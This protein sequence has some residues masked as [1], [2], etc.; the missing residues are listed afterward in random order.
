MISINDIKIL[1][2]SKITFEK[3]YDYYQK[4]NVRNFKVKREKNK[5]QIN[6]EVIGSN[7]NAYNVEVNIID[8]TKVIGE[9]ECEAAATY[10]GCCKHVIAVL[11]THSIYNSNKNTSSTHHLF[12]QPKMEQPIKTDDLALRMIEEYTNRSVNNA[13]VEYIDRKVKLVPTLELL[14]G[15]LMMN[16]SV[17]HERQYVIKDLTK[18]YNDMKVNNI[19]EYGKKLVFLHN[20]NS[21]DEDS[22]PLVKFLLNR[23][24]EYNYYNSQP[25]GYYRQYN[26]NRSVI[27]TPHSL[28]LIFEM[29]LNKSIKFINNGKEQVITFFDNL[30]GIEMNI[31][32]KTDD[33]FEVSLNNMKMIALEGESNGYLILEDKLYKLDE[34]FSKNVG[35]M[36]KTIIR[37]GSSLN[38]NKQDMH[39]FFSSVLTD[40]KDYLK[41]NADEK[42][43][44]EY[45]PIPMIAKLYVDIPE[46][47][48]ITGALKFVYG[49]IEFNSSE[50]IKKAE[51]YRSLKDEFIAKSLVN[52]Y[53]EYFDRDKSCYIIEN[54]DLIFNLYN[55]G[56]DDIAKVVQIYATDKFKSIVRKPPKVNLG[57]KISNNLLDIAFNAE[58]FPLDELFSIL[59]SYKKNRKFHRLKDG[60]FVNLENSSLSQL[61]QIA[62][63]L[64]LSQKDL[65]KGE[66]TVPKYRALYLDNII[67]NSEFIKSDRDINFKNIVRDM[68][69]VDDTSFI[70]PDNLKD[71]LRNYQKT[72]FHWLKTLSFYGFGG[73]LADDMGLGKT[74]EVIT[75]IQSYVNEEENIKPTLIVCPASLVL[76]WE[77]EI[78]R[79]APGL[80]ALCVI[81]TQSQRSE[82]LKSYQD[83]QIII[84]SYDYLKRDIDEY[85]DKEFM[86]HIIDEAQYIKNNN[87]LNSKSVKQIRSVCRFALTGTP[88]ENN[89]AEIWS[90]FEFVLPGYLYSYKKFYDQL[91]VPIVKNNDK[92]AVEKLRKIV[93][94][95]ILRRLKRDV[96]KELPDKTETTLF[97][98]LEGEQKKLY[99]A[100]LAMIKEQLSEKIETSGFNNS[101]IIILSMLTRLRQLCCHPSLY[102]EDYQDESAKLNMCIDL[103]ES[104]KASGHKILLFSQFTSMLDIIK[105]KLIENEVSHYVLE[106][107]TKKEE[108]KRLVE[109]FNQ[110]DTTVFLISLKAGGTGLNLTAADV[111]IHYDPWWNISAQNQATDRTHRIG[112][113]NNVTVYKLIAKDT[114]EEKI[115]KLQENK[116]LLSDSII[117]EDDGIITKMSQQEIMN[118]FED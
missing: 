50:D 39:A 118:L 104:S 70:I 42:I 106:G 21:F 54:D 110:D 86:Y 11:L 64:D 62:E 57:V 92:K 69:D 52:R 91:E 77:M 32:P 113:K 25:S 37:K 13:V 71:V 4:G 1:A 2:A 87:T 90:I 103:I 24:F 47:N 114:I 93:I 75:L 27:I 83:Y 112:Q 46:D 99:L 102:Y 6:A 109:E 29:F 89:L 79:F 5:V 16:F 81:G 82:L 63:G 53:F 7:E 101:K 117:V 14:N 95:F 45:E 3:G 56:L 105:T 74:I 59:S 15:K 94:P 97:V 49:E 111:V 8:D 61:S 80:K 67:K 58:E 66:V 108:R 68:N 10:D 22:K 35:T 19:V 65:E 33:L 72:G 76:N 116:Q 28:D 9:C 51:K 98:N 78:N 36:I 43:L 100:N 12:N 48:I 85:R 115:L 20:I 23:F 18:F 26:E 107:S 34:D 44:E 30:P 31:I 41:I 60:S 88:V 55:E 73:I 84:T 40:V 17:G 96:L 38:I